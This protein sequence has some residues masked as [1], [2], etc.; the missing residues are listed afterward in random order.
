MKIINKDLTVLSSSEIKFANKL[1]KK[2]LRIHYSYHMKICAYIRGGEDR[3][4]S[5]LHVILHI[6]DY[7]MAH[8]PAMGELTQL[9]PPV[10]SFRRL[11]LSCEDCLNCNNE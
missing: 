1:D 8:T 3:S 2:H 6:Q 11:A 4:P 5:V 9:L 7:P 10:I